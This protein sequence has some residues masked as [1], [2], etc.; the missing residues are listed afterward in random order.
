MTKAPIRTVGKF[1]SDHRNGIYNSNTVQ[2][3]RLI[4]RRPKLLIVAL[5]ALGLFVLYGKKRA[6]TSLAKELYLRWYGFKPQQ[7]EQKEEK[8]EHCL[9]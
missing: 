3:F 5:L 2:L 7:E 9:Q 6:M 4:F 8:L 1:L